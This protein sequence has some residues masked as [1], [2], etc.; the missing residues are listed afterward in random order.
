M[1]R[2]LGFSG[3]RD[4]TGLGIMLV[5]LETIF[6]LETALS[7]VFEDSGD[8]LKSVFVSSGSAFAV[9]V[10]QIVRRSKLSRSQ[11]VVG[12]FY[13]QNKASKGS[14]PHF[15]QFRSYS[16]GRHRNNHR[17]NPFPR[18]HHIHHGLRN[19]IW[20]FDVIK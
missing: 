11:A 3:L 7:L 8:G 14:H 12:S 18:F 5:F 1:Y 17:I 4:M 6:G 16:V 9:F 2:G 15:F 10:G 20:I 13:G 19:F